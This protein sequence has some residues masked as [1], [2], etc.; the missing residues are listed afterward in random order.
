[1]LGKFNLLTSLVEYA[2]K[3][4]YQTMV[5]SSFSEEVCLILRNDKYSYYV[6]LD[7]ENETTNLFNQVLVEKGD[8][9][10]VQKFYNIKAL[11]NALR[12]NK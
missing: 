4:N 5:I 12:S 3:Y 6:Y 9:K 2:E 10:P 7:L 1:M 8:N 11:E